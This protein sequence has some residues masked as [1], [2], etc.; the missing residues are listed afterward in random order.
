[1]PLLN[2]YF[3][4]VFVYRLINSFNSVAAS[5]IL[6]IYGHKLVKYTGRSDCAETLVRIVLC[7]LAKE[8]YCTTFVHGLEI[9][10]YDR[11]LHS[12]G[13][14]YRSGY[15]HTLLLLQ[16]KDSTSVR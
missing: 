12:K 7:H 5:C 8:L 2:I 13:S 11:Q 6:K 16:E 9:D 14:N 15:F 3:C 4:N 10:K 1:M